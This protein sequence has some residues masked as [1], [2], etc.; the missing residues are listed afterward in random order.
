MTSPENLQFITAIL[1]CVLG[2]GSYYFL[3]KNRFLIERFGSFC[4]IRETQEAQ[5]ILQR[6]LGLFFLGACSV[7]IIALLPDRELNEYGL[8]FHF[9]EAPPWWS[10]LLIP[11]ILVLGYRAAKTP[12]NLKQY[13]QIRTGTWT[14][15]LV[16]VSSIT[17]IA[18][19]VGYEFLFRGFV[20]FASLRS[21]G[22]GGNLWSHS[23]RHT[24]L[25]PDPAH[26]K[27]LD[28]CIITLGN[29]P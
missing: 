9:M 24:I 1:W 27:Y 2:F 7:F 8:S 16:A 3:S 4:R 20:L 21:E 11:L 22:T 5:V 26:R 14:G 29:G 25:L 15:S 6:L 19:L 17:W 18:F 23:G 13:P 28:R 10:W 12:D